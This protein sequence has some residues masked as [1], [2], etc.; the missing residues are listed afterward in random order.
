MSNKS[1]CGNNGHGQGIDHGQIA[2]TMNPFVVPIWDV[3]SGQPNGGLRSVIF[4]LCQFQMF[5]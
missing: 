4:I 1:T 2:A 5:L 3:G